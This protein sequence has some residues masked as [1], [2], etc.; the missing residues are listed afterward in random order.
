MY[1]WKGNSVAVNHLSPEKKEICIDK[2]Y[3]ILGTFQKEFY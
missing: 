3:L 1:L 2:T